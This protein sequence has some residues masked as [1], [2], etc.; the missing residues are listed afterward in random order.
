MNK[1]QVMEFSSIQA[2]IGHE[3]PY[4][5]ALRE[6]LGAKQA[7]IASDNLSAA[8][9]ASRGAAE[10]YRRLGN[11]SRSLD[12]YKASHRYFLDADDLSGA[13]WAMWAHGNLLRH[14]AD[15]PAAI[16]M[17]RQASSAA[18]RS[19]N[20]A[21]Q[22]YSLAGIAETHRITGNYSLA[23]QQHRYT[24]NIFKSLQD[25]RGIVWAYEG[26]AQMQKNSGN[27]RAA[28]ESFDR[29]RRICMNT[30]DIRGL[31][32]AMKGC[33]EIYAGEGSKREAIDYLLTAAS[34]FEE[35]KYGVGL[36]YVL[37][38]LGDTYL[39]FRVLDKAMD[40]YERA[41]IIFRDYADQ[42][43]QAFVKASQGYLFGHLGFFDES[44][45]HF[46]SALHSFNRYNIGYG[47]ELCTAGIAAFKLRNT[48]EAMEATIKSDNKMDVIV[49]DNIQKNL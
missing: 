39:R 48:R 37:K 33:G 8:G 20:N 40:Y 22:A 24:L 41:L 7:A 2:D 42:R 9:H 14:L 47:K 30:G 21:C 26:L 11:I 27:L 5:E 16:V 23:F 38:S 6:C 29:S 4:D 49:N 19:N 43:G 31:G 32:F 28:G 25:Y 46:V 18:H 10:C 36:A 13:S 34:I 35:L 3:M 1:I 45:T 12:E 17:L 44:Q 15:Y